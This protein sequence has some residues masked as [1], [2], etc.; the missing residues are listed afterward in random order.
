MHDVSS[1][2]PTNNMLHGVVD[3]VTPDPATARATLRRV[4]QL[5]TDRP[6]VD[7]PTHDPA[8]DARLT[9]RRVVSPSSVRLPA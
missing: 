3:G 4:Q 6:T 9:Q 5:V 2:S 7:L 1:I 8:A